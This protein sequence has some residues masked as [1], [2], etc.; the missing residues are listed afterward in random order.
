V[1]R[2]PESVISRSTFA[3]AAALFA[4]LFAPLVSMEHTAA[5]AH[6]LPLL[7]APL[8]LAAMAAILFFCVRQSLQRRPAGEP[9]FLRGFLA[10]AAVTAIASV[11]DGIAVFGL[12]PA[13]FMEHAFDNAAAAR[14]VGVVFAIGIALAAAFAAGLSRRSATAGA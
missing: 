14:S 8:T 11:L 2:T 3:Y 5:D 13:V 6:A 9:R 1:I 4:V 12:G 7:P 10:G